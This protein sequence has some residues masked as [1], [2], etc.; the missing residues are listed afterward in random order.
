M[1]GKDGFRGVEK[2]ENLCISS[3]VKYGH[4]WTRTSDPYDVNV[5]L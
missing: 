2:S 3:L 1:S 5:V 4:N